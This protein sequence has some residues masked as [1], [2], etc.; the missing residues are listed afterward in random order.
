MGG[1]SGGRG[2]ASDDRAGL[3]TVRCDPRWRRW[4][5]ARRGHRA[6]DRRPARGGHGVRDPGVAHGCHEVA[7]SRIRPQVI[8]GSVVRVRRGTRMRA[9][10]VERHGVDVRCVVGRCPRSG[11]GHLRLCGGCLRSFGRRPPRLQRGSWAACSEPL[12]LWAGS[13]PPRPPAVGIGD[14]WGPCPRSRPRVGGRGCRAGTRSR[15][16]SAQVLPYTESRLPPSRTTSTERRA[17]RASLVSRAAEPGGVRGADGD[18]GAQP[19]AGEV[20]GLLVGDESPSF[21]GDD[22]VGGPRGL[23]GVGG[24][25]QDRAALGRRVRAACRAAIGLR[26]R[27]DRRRGRRARGCA[28][29]PAGR[30]PGRGGG[31]CPARACPGVRSRRLT[32]PTTSRTSSARRAGHARGRAQHAQMASD[33]AGGVPGHVAEEHADLA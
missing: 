27:T 16:S 26:G 30:R 31:P 12:A 7:E 28:G 10:V 2:P 23:L 18:P 4:H 5:G 15:R 24:G 20:G 6:R 22:P 3:A 1:G 29:R 21:Q 32:R 8:T 11:R 13:G 14:G 25:E 19:G 33:R 9:E 17:V